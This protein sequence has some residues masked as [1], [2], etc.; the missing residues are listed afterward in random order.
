MMEMF[1]IILTHQ[2]LAILLFPDSSLDIIKTSQ[3]TILKIDTACIRILH[4][5]KCKPV[6]LNRD[7]RD[8]QIP[9]DFLN[10]IQMSLDQMVNSWRQ[11]I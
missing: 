2:A 10:N 7:I 3:R 8:W 6:Y 4:L 5:H 1:D 11:P 9:A